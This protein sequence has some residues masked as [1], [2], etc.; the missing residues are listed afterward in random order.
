MARK[1]DWKLECGDV[2][3]V[4]TTDA[5]DE[6]GVALIKGEIETAMDAAD[7]VNGTPTEGIEAVVTVDG[8]TYDTIVGNW[9]GLGNLQ[10]QLDLAWKRVRIKVAG[11]GATK[12]AEQAAI[13]L[14]E[15]AKELL[16]G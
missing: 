8:E 12:E 4:G 1:L 2:L 3:V 7:L 14:L 10:D 16:R 15:R 9:D 13:G 11:S 5:N 6:A